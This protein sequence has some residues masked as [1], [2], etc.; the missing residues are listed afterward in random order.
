MHR[1]EKGD[2]PH[3][4]SDDGDGEEQLDEDAT[5]HENG[6]D[7]DVLAVPAMNLEVAEFVANV[8]EN[9]FLGGFCMLWHH[10]GRYWCKF[11]YQ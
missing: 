7:N 9:I 2:R 11:R 3:R 8:Q 4:D 5:N 6:D 10:F 1:N